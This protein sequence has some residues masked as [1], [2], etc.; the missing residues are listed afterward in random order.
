M[1]ASVR[2]W[3]LWSKVMISK[4]LSPAP[5][6]FSLPH[7]RASLIAPSLAS[8]PQLVKNT[9]SKQ[10]FCVNSVASSIIGAL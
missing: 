6:G 10:E 3:K 1:V 9:R 4:R 7:L 8:A 2:P 5:F